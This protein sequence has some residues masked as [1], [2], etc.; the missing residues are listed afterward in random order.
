M[1]ML[2]AIVAL[3]L[4]GCA[5]FVPQPNMNADQLKALASDKNASAICSTILGPWGTGKLVVVNLD[6]TRIN[7]TVIVNPDCTITATTTV[8]PPIP[9]GSTAAVPSVVPPTPVEPAK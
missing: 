9:R 4:V 2:A 5:S 6:E 7:G 8:P 1:K 3:F